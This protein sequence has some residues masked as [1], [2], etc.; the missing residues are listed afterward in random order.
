[1]E[2]RTRIIIGPR[3]STVREVDQIYV[4]EEGRIVEQG[5]HEELSALPDGVYNK[6]AKLQFDLVE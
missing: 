1:M 5:T 4:L 6:L 2:N 3:L